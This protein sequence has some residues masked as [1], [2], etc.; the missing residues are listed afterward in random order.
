MKLSKKKGKMICLKAMEEKL[1]SKNDCLKV[2]HNNVLEL[3]DKL[4][5][6]LDSLVNDLSINNL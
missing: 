6:K 1:D 3:G 4:I 5:R 2:Y